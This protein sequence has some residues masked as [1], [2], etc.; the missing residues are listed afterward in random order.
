M[1]Q[2]VTGLALFGL[3]LWVPFG[4]LGLDSVA[5]DMP[6]LL[7]FVVVG[8]AAS[9]MLFRSAI[10]GFFRTYGAD[11]AAAKDDAPSTREF[12]DRNRNGLDRD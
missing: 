4:F 12:Y 3:T 9:L 11:Q 1:R 2:L 10:K 8:A 6:I 5:R 7:A